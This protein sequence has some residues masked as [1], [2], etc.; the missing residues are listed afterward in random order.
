[1]NFI[2]EALYAL[3]ITDIIVHGDVNTE[4]EFLDQC[5]KVVGH[6]SSNEAICSS[7]PDD[8][9]VTWAEVKTKMDEFRAEYDSQA[10]ARK[11]AQEYPSLAEQLDLLWHAIDTDTLDNKDYRNK[12]YTRLKKV[13][14]DNPKG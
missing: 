4:K 1:M 2:I 14:E 9:G 12:F 10:Y 5:K 7:D 11:R 3:N 8:F 6:T 13:K